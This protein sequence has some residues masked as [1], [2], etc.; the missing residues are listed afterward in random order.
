MYVSSLYIAWNI[1]HLKKYNLT[2][3]CTNQNE[4]ARCASDTNLPRFV[5]FIR[6]NL[7]QAFIRE[8]NDQP[9]RFIDVYGRDFSIKKAE[10]WG[11]GWRLFG[12]EQYIPCTGL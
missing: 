8:F 10:D 3:G 6:P 2:T 7:N 4:I 5:S 11:E 12:Y 9:P 1:G